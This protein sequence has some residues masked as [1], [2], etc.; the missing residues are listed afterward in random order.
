MIVG[1]IMGMK[2][3]HSRE[4]LHRDLKPGNLL[5]DERVHLKI[6]DFAAT[7]LLD[8]GCV[9][10]NQVNPY[11]APEVLEGGAPSKKADVFAFGLI[12]YEL[13]TGTSVFPKGATQA[14][15]LDLQRA[16]TRPEIP[17]TIGRP[18]AKL[19]ERCWSKN[20]ADRPNF[21]ETYRIL[22]DIWFPLFP[23][24]SADAIEAYIKEMKELGV[25]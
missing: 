22:E 18:V 19:I 4:I 3:L 13:L 21:D 2:Y 14:Q 8:C 5:L 12:V 7:R 25:K 1:F 10:N 17:K 9:A 24:V 6:C 11:V 23:D 20:P 16:G 15:I